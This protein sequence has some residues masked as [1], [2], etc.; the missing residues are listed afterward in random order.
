MYEMENANVMYE[1]WK[2]GLRRCDRCDIRQNIGKM[3]WDNFEGSVK[4]L[5]DKEK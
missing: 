5:E 2:K 4:E 1:L 3:K